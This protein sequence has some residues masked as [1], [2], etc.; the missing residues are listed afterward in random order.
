MS[1]EIASIFLTAHLPSKLQY[2][3]SKKL[4]DQR[5]VGNFGS[6][7]VNQTQAYENLN[8]IWGNMKETGKEL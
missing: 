5:E 7:T 1:A 4:S 2:K 6:V 3:L 8:T